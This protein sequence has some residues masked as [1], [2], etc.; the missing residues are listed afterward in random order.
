MMRMM[1]ATPAAA[2]IAKT[3]SPLRR[4]PFVSALAASCTLMHAQQTPSLTTGRRSASTSAS[5]QPA[6]TTAATRADTDWLALR[7]SFKINA[8]NVRVLHE[9]SDFFSTLLKGVAQAKRQITLASLYLGT[10]ARERELIEALHLALSTRP[11]L[12]VNILLDCMRGSRGENEKK[13]SRAMLLPLLER[14]GDRITLSLYHTPLLRSLK[15]KLIPAKFD[16]TISVQHMKLYMW[17]DTIL[18]SGANL[19]QDYFTNRQDRYMLF[20]D[21][22]EV[23]GFFQKV[24]RVVEEHSYRV[25]SK[26]T[27]EARRFDPLACSIDEF[28]ASMAAGMRAILA[29]APQHSPAQ[30]PAST[31]ALV[32]PSIQLGCFGFKHDQAITS[33]ILSS[34]PTD[35]AVWVASGYFNFPESYQQLVLGQS[36]G[37]TKTE[38]KILTA[39]PLVSLLLLSTREEKRRLGEC[40]V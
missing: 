3:A 8:S 24:S 39:A 31:E 30:R 15:K 20:E 40:S 37:A 1:M 27:L 7:P 34:T 19:S 5:M 11:E 16:E 4:R 29:Q 14:F 2:L 36:Q 33:H 23:V 35:C 21:C 6:T 25:S 12:R 9:P 32:L 13:S 10:G 28:G 38:F 17:D 18:L 26:N 22:P